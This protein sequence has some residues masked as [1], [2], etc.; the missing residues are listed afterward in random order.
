VLSQRQARW[1][2]VLSSYDIVI[3]HLEGM[4]DPA[5]GPSRRPDYEIGYER[6]TSQLLATLSII[7]VEPYDDLLQ[8]SKTAQ[9]ID[10]LAANVTHR[11]ALKS[12]ISVTC[13]E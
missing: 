12:S 1:E 7:T 6:Q 13:K 11:M 8:E 5:D 4:K 2:E 9:G 3:E 10:A